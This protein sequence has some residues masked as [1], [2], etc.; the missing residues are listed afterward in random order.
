MNHFNSLFVR[1][2]L[3]YRTCCLA[4]MSALM[5]LASPMAHAAK[6]STYF[7]G[8]G[9]EFAA[10]LRLGLLIVAGVGILT[11]GIAILTWIQASRRNEPAKWQ[12]YGVIGGALATIVPLIVLAMAGSLSNETGGAANMFNELG[13]QY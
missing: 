10:G 12:L 9:T 4:V 1:I 8:I 5:L 3:Q 13:I 2:A 11:A 6:M 7:T